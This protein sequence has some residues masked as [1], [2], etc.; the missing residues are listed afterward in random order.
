MKEQPNEQAAEPDIEPRDQSMRDLNKTLALL[1]DGELADLAN[2]WREHRPKLAAPTADPVNTEQTE[3]VKRFG[4]SKA[5]IIAD[6]RRER[7]GESVKVGAWYDD[8]QDVGG[9]IGTHL[10][11]YKFTGVPG[12][13]EYLD[14]KLAALHSEYV[15]S[16]RAAMGNGETVGAA[17]GHVEAEAEPDI[18]PLTDPTSSVRILLQNI[19]T[20]D[21]HEIA[22]CIGDY[23]LVDQ[24]RAALSEVAERFNERYTAYLRRQTAG[25]TAEPVAAG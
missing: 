9:D 25:K 7:R 20:D 24:C 11:A 8:N 21:T 15:R 14:D 3:L 12:V 4:E 2:E 5:R 18:K 19:E 6:V 1:D 22:T 10:F 17:V 23:D 13:A 16:Q